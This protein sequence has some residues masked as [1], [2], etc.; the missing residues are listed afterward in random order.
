MR[1]FGFHLPHSKVFKK[2]VQFLKKLSAFPRSL[3]PWSASKQWSNFKDIR[4]SD[5]KLEKGI[6][7]VH[8][9]IGFGI[10]FLIQFSSPSIPFGDWEDDASSI[11]LPHVINRLAETGKKTAIAPIK[12]CCLQYFALSLHCCGGCAAGGPQSKLLLV[13][14]PV[15]F[16]TTGTWAFVLQRATRT[17]PL[18]FLCNVEMRCLTICQ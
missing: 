18:A 6:W 2:Q 1:P 9:G 11:D 4:L 8:E 5:M 15:L 3:A 7:D 13:Q 14:F 17:A 12:T 10:E 16:K